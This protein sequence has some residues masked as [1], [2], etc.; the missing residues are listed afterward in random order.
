M[1]VVL[2]LDDFGQPKLYMGSIL[3]RTKISIYSIYVKHIFVE[4][5]YIYIYM[6]NC[7]YID[8]HILIYIYML[9]NVYVIYD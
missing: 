5:S 7:N 4:L 8:I 3:E 2:Y 1:L 9:Y 6:Y